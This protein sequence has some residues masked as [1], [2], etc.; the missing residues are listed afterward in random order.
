V[1]SGNVYLSRGTFRN[2]VIKRGGLSVY[3]AAKLGGTFTID[4]GSIEDSPGTAFT[5]GS[6]YDSYDPVLIMVKA[7]RIVRS[8][9]AIASMRISAFLEMWPTAEAQAALLDNVSR[10]ITLSA[11]NA[12]LYDLHLRKEF[13]WGISRL[14][15]PDLPIGKLT[16]EPGTTVELG[17]FARVATL[18][19]P[20]TADQP[21]TVSSRPTCWGS[22]GCGITVTDSASS[23]ISNVQFVNSYIRFSR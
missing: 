19:A 15:L 16:L 7:P 11:A 4:G 2:T 9:G 17:S 8:R 6:L 14:F 3:Y 23:R 22:G 12:T 18:I 10:S 5:F 20:G 13:H 21:I 1:D